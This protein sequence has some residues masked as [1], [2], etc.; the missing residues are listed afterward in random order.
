MH[1]LSSHLFHGFHIHIFRSH[2]LKLESPNQI[3][4]Y[5]RIF[6]CVQF[7]LY[8]AWVEIRFYLF[9]NLIDDLKF[10]SYL[11]VHRRRL[12]RSN[13]LYIWPGRIQ[14]VFLPHHR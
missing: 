6:L 5:K 9:D 2:F 4:G 14:I 12:L 3:P 1:I 10:G 11:M 8:D 13:H 7:L